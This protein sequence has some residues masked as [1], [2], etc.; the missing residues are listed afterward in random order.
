LLGFFLLAV[1]YVA[2]A[3][4]YDTLLH[5][6]VAFLLCYGLSFFISNAGA[7]TTTYVIPSEAFPTKVRSPCLL[8]AVACVSTSYPHCWQVR[9][10]FHGISAASG[11]LGAVV[12]ALGMAGL[13]DNP[14]NVFCV[15]SAIAVVG[16]ILTFFCTDESRGKTLQEMH[17]SEEDGPEPG[18]EPYALMKTQA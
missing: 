13:K 11:K 1:V 10:T 15:C 2:I 14:Y 3:I 7:N 4:A 17:G 18:A 8:A 9:A 5:N 12:G 6:P 16:A